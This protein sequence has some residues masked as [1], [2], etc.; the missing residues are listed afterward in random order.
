MKKLIRRLT[1]GILTAALCVAVSGCGSSGQTE[2]DEGAAESTA[3]AEVSADTSDDGEVSDTLKKLRE[4]GTLVVGSSGDVYAYIDQETGEFKGVDADICKEIAKRL[5]IENVEM[6]LIPFSELIL[7]LNAKNIDIIADGMYA[8]EER[9]QQIYYGDVW[10]TQGGALLVPEG[11]AIQGKD[12]FDPSSTVVGYTPGTIW[13]N[14]V[15]NWAS[16]GL[17]K[18]A[19][20]TGDQSESIVALQYGKIDAFL[21]DSTVVE[22]L[23]ANDP[24]VVKGLMLAENFEDEPSMI[25]RIAPAVSFD[26]IAFMKEVNEVVKQMREEGVL[27]QIFVDNGLDPELHMITNS[28][29]DTKHGMNTREE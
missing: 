4:K 13:Q 20:A 10:Y 27:D 18:E 26:D 22:D 11:S 25:G 6:S 12:N 3:S 14:A 8:N 19:R 24:D 21:T 9:A 1:A 28:D 15:E 2:S 16:Q 7:N 23:L 5:G 17:I 29:E